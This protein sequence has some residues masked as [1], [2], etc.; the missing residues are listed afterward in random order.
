MLR[1][2][3]TG[4]GCLSLLLFIVL[5]FVSLYIGYTLAGGD[6]GSDPKVESTF[7]AQVFL[8]GAGVLVLSGPLHWLLGWVLNTERTPSKRRWHNQHTLGNL[9]VQYMFSYNLVL[10]LIFASLG[11]GLLTSALYGWL[12]FGVTLVVTVQIAVWW[13]KR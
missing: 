11:L 5:L 8:I 12:L 13:K 1:I 6:P 3:W 2:R 9:P 7:V 10:A 4:L